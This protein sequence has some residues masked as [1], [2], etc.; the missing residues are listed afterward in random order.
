MPNI[1]TI[2]TRGSALALWQSNAVA[3]MLRE[4]HPGLTI[5]LEII[6][7]KGDKVLDVSLDKIGDKGLFTKELE[8]AL[9]EEK[10]DLAVHSL[11]D[12]QTVLPE[13]LTLGAVTERAAPEDVLIGLSGV[14]LQG[15]RQGATVATGSLR[16]RAQLLA[17]RSD[18]TVVDLRGNVPTR[19]QKF[20]DSDWDGIILARAGLERLELTEEIAQIIPTDLMIPA[21]G[22]GAL[23]IEIRKED[24]GVRLLVEAIEHPT[25]RMTTEAERSFLRRLEGGCQAP[26]AAHATLFEGR[27]RLKGLIASLD[28]KEVV[29]D[30]IISQAD[31]EVGIRLAEKLLQEGGREI[32]ESI[33]TPG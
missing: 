13:G 2:G 3:D 17:L 25:T 7:T 33:A 26:I 21:V 27:L 23:G 4:A 6:E 32:L 30:S 8:T 22:Q 16:R 10:V 29:Q 20:H 28:G 12:M 14:T 24:E 11:K 31:S 1:L 15:L 18:I 5:S 19:L 9:M